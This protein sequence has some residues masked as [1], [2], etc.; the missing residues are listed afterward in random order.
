MHAPERTEAAHEEVYPILDQCNQEPL[1]PVR[2]MAALA[3]LSLTAEEE[4]AMGAEM[5]AMVR[6]VRALQAVDTRDVSATAH[7]TAEENVLRADEV[8]SSVDRDEMLRNAPAC[9]DGCILVPQALA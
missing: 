3:R 1:M 9:A 8:Q 2:R 5:D 4:I 6:F 7:V